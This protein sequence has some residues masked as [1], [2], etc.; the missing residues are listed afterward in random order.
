MLLT[1]DTAIRDVKIGLEFLE[2]SSRVLEFSVRDPHFADSQSRT[3]S[4][5]DI[6]HVA[7][8]ANVAQVNLNTASKS[9]TTVASLLCH[10]NLAV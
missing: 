8:T 7:L 6:E 5:D 10:D 2:T 4:V 9:D 3:A 1:S